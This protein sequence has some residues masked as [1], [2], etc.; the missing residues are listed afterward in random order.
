MSRRLALQTVHA[1]YAVQGRL[2]SGELWTGPLLKSVAASGAGSVTLEFEDW[3]AVALAL[4]DVHAQNLDKTG[5][6][7]SNNC[8]RCCA[9]A[10]PFE[11]L[12]GGNWTRID[13]K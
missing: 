12:Q 5:K 7:S 1:A 8:I 10:A 3:S 9:A 2:S 13:Q 4:Q 11:V 6:I